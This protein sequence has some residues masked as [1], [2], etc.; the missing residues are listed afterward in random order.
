MTVLNQTIEIALSH[1]SKM[2]ASQF[3]ADVFS[4]FGGIR[5]EYLSEFRSRIERL[6]G[7]E[8]KPD[9]LVFVLYT[10]GGLVEAVERMVDIIRHHYKEVWF[11]VPDIAMSAGTIFCMSGD[12]IYM[13]YS[14]ALGPIDPQVENSEGR[15]VPALGYLDR[16]EKLIKK[17]KNDELTDAEF[18]M[19]QNQDFAELQQYEQAQKLSISLL[20]KWLVKYKFKNWDT[21]SSNGEAVTPEEKS[22]R[23]E[24]IATDLSNHKKWLSHARMIGIET[25]TRDLKLKIEDYSNKPSL[26]YAIREYSDLIRDCMMNHGSAYMFHTMGYEAENTEPEE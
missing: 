15:F 8:N 22:N 26:K 1:Y 20:K 21:H 9:Q 14:S 17:S 12:R 11:I 18:A 25:L 23:A 24:K 3:Q 2:V 13:D 6:V 10:G 16:V 19:L 4:Y 7:R 5:F